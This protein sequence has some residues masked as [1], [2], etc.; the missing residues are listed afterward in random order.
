MAGK[1]KKSPKSVKLPSKKTSEKYALIS[2]FDKTGIVEFAKSLVNLNYKIISTG[3][4]AKAL[5][6]EGIK[7]IP[8]QEITGNPESFDGRMKTI[9]FQIESGILYD[10]KNPKHIKEAKKLKIKSIDIVVCNLYPFEKTVSDPKV[11]LKDAIEN[12][13]V[14]GP[15]MIRAAAKNNKNVLVITDPMDYQNIS[16]LLSQNKIDEKVRLNLSAKAFRHL[17]F[18]DSQIANYLEFGKGNFINEI[19]IPG[20]KVIDLRYGDNPHQKAA[21]YIE[22]NTNSPLSKLEKITGRDLS[23]TNFTDISSGLESV[24]IFKEPAAVVIKHNSPSGI[25]LANSASEALKRAVAADPESAFGGVIVLNEPI[26]LKTAK[27]FADF[28]EENGVLIDIIAAPSVKADAVEFIKQIRK[29][30]GVY[31][32]GKIPKKRSNNKHL[33]FF[34]GGFVMQDF[35]DNLSFKDWKVVTKS[36]PTSSQMKQ[37]KIAWSFIGRIRSN[38]IL[39]IDKNLPMTRGIGSGQT[40]RVRAT[41]I[42]LEQAGKNVNGGILA[43]DSFFPFDDSVKLAVKAG[44]S[45]IVQ[46]G[47]SVNDQASINEANK[48]GIPMVFT[49]QRKF[50]H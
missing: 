6:D 39:V 1:I 28:K 10:R 13:D 50:W 30:T 33:R 27:T 43:S 34:D 35:D 32:F 25:A 15:T 18:Y 31:V 44:I 16:E 12:I 22:P 23:A 3:G 9:S 46:Q 26:D 29:S 40:S 8:I 37:M 2:V 19:A 48:A 11:T 38:T 4:T 5:L 41:K 49:G 45:A 47:G 20:R 36:K 21:V 14:G 24:R 17:S 42:A 7:I